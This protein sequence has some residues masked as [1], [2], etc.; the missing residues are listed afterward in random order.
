MNRRRHQST[1]P[2]Q[3]VLYAR[4]AKLWPLREIGAIQEQVDQNATFCLEHGYLVPHDKRLAAV[5][6]GSADSDRPALVRLLEAIRLGSVAIMVMR[7]L[8]RLAREDPAQS[9]ILIEKFRATG[10]SITITAS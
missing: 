8:D 2:K 7:D 1:E 3:V 9:A 10:V 4:S 6:A 5:Q